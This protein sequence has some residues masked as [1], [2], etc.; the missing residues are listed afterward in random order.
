MMRQFMRFLVRKVPRPWLIRFSYTFG[1]LIQWF[2]R[3]NKVNCPVC[4]GNFRKFLPYG[5]KGWDNRLCPKCLSLERHRLL[6]LFLQK[7]TD[8]FTKQIRM[9]HIAPEQPFYN[10]FRKRENIDYLTG[11]LESPIADVK[12]DIQKMPFDN[13]RFDVI[14]C[15]HVLEHVDNDHL[16]MQEL[17]R[18]T[19]TGGWVLIQIPIDTSRE[20]TYENPE[21]TDEKEREKHFGQYDHVRLYGLDFARRLENAGFRVETV[22]YAYEVSKEMFERH[23][24]IKE[25]FFIGYKN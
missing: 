11:D 10:R 8:F 12:F 16:A 19:K 18:T 15:N 7:K 6:W 3:G 9:L 4:G 24:F 13:E 21:I 20:T 23:R 25:P 2:Y 5:N 17:Y 22:R 14:F 1:W